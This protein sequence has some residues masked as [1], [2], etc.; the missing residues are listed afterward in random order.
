MR[1]SLLSLLLA[2]T[3]AGA[4]HGQ[5]VAPAASARADDPWLWLEPVRSDSAMQW[6]HAENAVT[7][8]KYAQSPAFD[9]LRE[10]IRHVLDS[11]ARIPY[12]NRMG[13]Y[14]YNFWRDQAH[15][16]GIWRR[17]TLE[18]Y[19]KPEPRWDVLLDVD[20]LGRAEGTGW[21]YHGA[22]CL[23]PAYTRC[24]VSLSPNGGDASAVREFDLTTRRFVENGFTLSA[25]KSRVSWIDQ[26]HIYI[27]TDFGPGSMTTSSYPRIAKRWRRGTPLA[28]ATVVYEGKPTDMSVSAYRDRTP[29]YQRDFISVARDFYHDTRYLLQDGKRIKVDVP[30]DAGVDFHR[31]W[32][33]LELRSS[34]TTG[35][36]TW[37]AGALLAIK[38]DAFLGGAR[39]FQALFLPTRHTSLAS[40]RWTRHHLILGLL[41]DVKSRLEVL[42]PGPGEWA[43]APLAGAPALSTVGV[44]DTD[45]DST[46]EYWLSVEGFLA[47]AAL[48]RGVLDSVEIETIKQGPAFFDAT[49]YEVTQHFVSSKDGTQVPYFQVSG[50]GMPLDGSHPTLLFGYGGFEISE[51]PAYDGVLGPA[52]LD[53]GGVYV[54]ANIRGGGE[55]GPDWHNAALREHRSRAYEDFAAVAQDLVD[56]GVTTPTHLGAEGR[57]N[58][59]LLMGNMYT[60]WPQLFGAIVC[61]VPLLDMKRYTHLSAGAS[62]I[63]EYGDPDKPADWTFIRTFSPYQNVRAG[64]DYPPILFYTATSDDRV[65][66]VQARKMTAKLQSMGYGNVWLHE[67][68]EGGHAGS[69]DNSQL[70]F[71]R[72]LTYRFLWEKLR[73]KRLRAKGISFRS[74]AQ[75]LIPLPAPATPASAQCP[76]D[77]RPGCRPAARRGGRAPAPQAGCWRRRA[78]RPARRMADRYDAQS[79]CRTG[80]FRPESGAAPARHSAGTR[81]PA[82][83]AAGRLPFRAAPPHPPPVRRAWHRHE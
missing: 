10:T 73:A 46:D 21:V 25:A 41:D 26:D 15:P 77:T 38:A 24:L 20:S 52:W 80:C 43:R 28:S 11:D 3:L 13:S 56:R 49:P 57:S 5:G 2:S 67:N 35:G 69:S 63:A 19:R 8:A 71:R 22:Q 4:L 61:G 14:L 59:G 33:L 9:S 32:L 47:P 55:Y 81:C 58:G 34:W 68:T 74:S 79:H 45:P 60:R 48:E 31:E 18:E 62:W 23:E 44:V 66:P 51:V 17:T 1:I 36:R 78:P 6:V 76:S 54:V 12:V 42:T 83:R 7:L 39:E 30:E 82:C 50:K 27:G 40:H 75:S 64:M 53:R 65:G 16:R 29:G 72:A 70:A 37:P